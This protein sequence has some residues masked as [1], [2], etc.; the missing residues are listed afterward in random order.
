MEGSARMN[1]LSMENQAAKDRW[2]K[3]VWGLRAKAT[4][5]SLQFCGN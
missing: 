3:A 4:D 2:G 1:I 5:K